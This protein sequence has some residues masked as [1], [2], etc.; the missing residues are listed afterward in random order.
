MSVNLTRSEHE[1][2]SRNSKLA[3]AVN[4][5]WVLTNQ[6]HWNIS[7]DALRLTSKWGKRTLR[8]APIS[9]YDSPRLP[10][11]SVL[12][13]HPE[14]LKLVPKRWQ[15]NP[16]VLGALAGVCVLMSGCGKSGAK[17]PPSR[18]APIF[19]HG[20]GR[21]SF[22]C[23][24]VNP[25]VLL[26]EAEARQVIVEEARRAGIKL[27]P[28]SDKLGVRV[29]MT[30]TLDSTNCGRTRRGALVIDGKDGR[31]HV[32]Y[33]FVS[34]KDFDNWERR[35]LLD[36]FRLSTASRRDVL[37]AA[38]SLRESIADSKPPGAYAVFYDPCCGPKDVNPRFELL[39]RPS[40]MQPGAWWAKWRGQAKD[41]AEDQ[42]R[43]Q[44]RDFI[45]W[46]KAQG[47]I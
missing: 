7:A 20:S 39:R 40:D 26:S 37:G 41:L 36:A 23:R 4:P 24:A 15:R 19:V 13:E 17:S 3:E 28:S 11:H 16:V 33:E 46:L 31:K 27:L 5:P 25:P 35:G 14:L 12:D 47:V 21:G 44:V 43:A 22:G 10:T 32:T 29:P 38:R 2:V 6:W 45:K 34:G 9:G 30:S 42:L 18:V 1:F 8:V